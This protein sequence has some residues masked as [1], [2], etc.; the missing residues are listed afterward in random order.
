MRSDSWARLSGSRTGRGTRTR[1][2]PRHRNMLPVLSQQAHAVYAGD[3]GNCNY[4]CHILEI[5][6]IIGFDVG[7]PL[8][9]NGENILQPFP[10]AIP[11][12]HLFIHH[13]LRVFYRR[14]LCS[15]LR[16]MDLNH[17]RPIGRRDCAACRIGLW[18]LCLQTGWPLLDHNHHE[19]D[20]EHQQNVNQGSDVHL[21][22]RRTTACRGECH[23]KFSSPARACLKH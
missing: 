15:Q 2:L 10:Q 17:N 3:P 18:N 6:V 19:N 21:W 20:D 8:D 16:V 23:L 9:A 5:N 14:T 12:H 11:F 1:G 7:D 22:T 13:Y 4:I